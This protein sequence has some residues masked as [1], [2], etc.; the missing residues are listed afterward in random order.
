MDRFS[1]CD[2]LD[3]V[4]KLH[5]FFIGTRDQRINLEILILLESFYCSICVSVH[6]HCGLVCCIQVTN[7]LSC[8]E[9]PGESPECGNQQLA[10]TWS[11]QLADSYDILK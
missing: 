10:G 3:L 5:D 6:H 9:Y 4:M 8:T 2:A 1:T 11:A 7:H